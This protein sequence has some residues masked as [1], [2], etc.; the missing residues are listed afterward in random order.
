MVPARTRTSE[1]AEFIDLEHVCERLIR[2]GFAL[3]S[4]VC[5]LNWNAQLR[6]RVSDPLSSR[7]IEFR[8]QLICSP[9]VRNHYAAAHHQRHVDRFFLLGAAHTQTIALNHVVVDAIVTT[10]T[11]GGDQAHQFFVFR[12]HGAFEV[13]VVIEVVKAFDQEVVGLVDIFVQ[14]GPGVLE[15]AGLIRFFRLPVFR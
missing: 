11:G 12:G 5:Y 2:R 13:G 8:Q 14:T 6:P 3:A 1:V 15:N 4:E 10:Q 7:C 9:H